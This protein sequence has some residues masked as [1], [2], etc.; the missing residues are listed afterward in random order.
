MD[1]DFDLERPA[2]GLEDEGYAAELQVRVCGLQRSGN[3]A[4]IN[5]IINQHKGKAY[6]FLNNVRHG[7]YDPFETCSQ[8]FFENLSCSPER[9]ALRRVAKHLLVLSY[10]DDDTQMLKNTGFLKSVFDPQFESNRRRYLGNSR[11]AYDVFIVRD[12]FNFFASRLTKWER[13]TGRKD[14]DR[15]VHDWKEMARAA[16]ALESDPRPQALAISYNAWHTD[17]SYRKELSRRLLGHHDDSSMNHVSS[18]GGGSSFEA[19]PLTPRMLVRNWRKAFDAKRLTMLHHYLGRI[20]LRERGS[21]MHVLERWKGFRQDDR[22]L[23]VFADRELLELSE[24][25][26]GEIPDS[27]SFVERISR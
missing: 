25:I 6:C 22:F 21:K 16:I 19:V 2:S 23:S 5:W 1:A 18:I 17:V 10:E 14:V 11:Y 15:V 26:F 8:L 13:L 4:I 20:A 12:P 9:E 7:S 24:Q 27:R 3:H